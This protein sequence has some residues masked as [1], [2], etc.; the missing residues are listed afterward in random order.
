LLPKDET[1]NVMKLPPE[2]SHHQAAKEEGFFTVSRVLA[3]VAIGA[4]AIVLA[5]HILP[6]LG[7]GGASA[8]EALALAEEAG[9]A[10]GHS[11]AASGLA[12]SINTVLGAVPFVGAKL[13]E[14]GLFAG[15]AA[16]V[17]G[18]GG[19]LLSNFV[20]QK[21]DGTSSIKWSKVIKY[22]ALA[23]S[24]IIALPTA[25]TSLGV[26]LIYLASL[27]KGA[28]LLSPA[29]VS[30]VITG[31]GATL[32]TIG[33]VAHNAMMG[34]SGIGAAIPHF[35][36][37]GMTMVP[38]AMAMTVLKEDPQQLAATGGG[39]RVEMLA[40][41]PLEAG[42]PAHLHIRLRAGDGHYLT[43]NELEVTHTEKLHLLV[44]DQSLGDYHHVHPKATDQPDVFEVSF[45]PR[46]SNR[47][48]AWAD[49]TPALDG[50]NRVIATQLPSI[51]HRN[52][53]P[54]VRVNDE[55]QVGDIQASWSSDE[56]LRQGKGAMVHVEL[57]DAAGKP[58]TDLEPV[59]GAY[60]HLVGF[61]ADG[62]TLVHSHPL[63]EEPKTSA[64]RGGPR[65]DFHVE[66][67]VAGATQ[68]YLQVQRGGQEVMLPFGQ[69]IAPPERRTH[70]E[71]VRH[72]AHA[73]HQHASAGHAL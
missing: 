17:T 11:T 24:A 8:G 36:T 72:P 69:R 35:L 73:H 45:T 25:L 64:E 38:T 42:K 37:C 9:A 13:T 44:V 67:H 56:P 6:A 59:M 62:K 53:P 12:G 26:G 46:T 4:A 23:T 2:H 5:P 51:S 71:M 55:A 68:F 60:A 61:S 40:N 21:E 65:L 7:V 14:G 18:I 20:A 58:I 47:Y 48:T 70:A 1:N 32:G 10:L 27:A 30:N 29:A 52:V 16:G 63:G 19:V 49:F 57:R 3:G 50:R 54:M 22:A 39:M 31:V 66:P 28:G 15:L 34:L 41:A 33:G 43:S